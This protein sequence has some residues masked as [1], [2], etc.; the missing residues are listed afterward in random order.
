MINIC[1]IFLNVKLPLDA[2]TLFYLVVDLGRQFIADIIILRQIFHQSLLFGL[3]NSLKPNVRDDT[4][5][6]VCEQNKLSASI[7]VRLMPLYH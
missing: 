1:R 7:T 2:A 5:D 6:V 3:R 4:S